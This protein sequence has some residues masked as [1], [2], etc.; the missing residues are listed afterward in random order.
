MGSSADDVGERATGSAA[1]RAGEAAGASR[2]VRATQLAV[3]R[4]LDVVLASLGLAA[5][6]PLLLSV[7][8]YI[9]FREGGPVLFRQRRVGR[10]GRI[11]TLV[12]FRT[13]VPDAEDRL[14][15]IRAANEVRGHAFKL[16]R[17][18]RVTRSG[19]VLRRWSI[20]EL[21]QL[22]NVLRG[23]MSLVG[24]RPPLPSEVTAYE[25]WHLRRLSMTPGLTGH[26]QVRARDE[27]DFDRWVAVDL[28]YIDRWSLRLD[29]E[30]MLRTIPVVLRGN[31]R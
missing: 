27:A 9:R 12:K 24:P 11:F 29:L 1:G 2:R 10:D 5:T 18:P 14:D 7:A 21:P 28:E 13:M 8:C 15:A 26:W 17:D 20:D 30:I 6:A 19:R 25:G 4:A 3:K 22:W 31:G 16:S 23:E